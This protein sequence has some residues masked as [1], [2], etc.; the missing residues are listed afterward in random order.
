MTQASQPAYRRFFKIIVKGKATYELDEKCRLKPGAIPKNPPRKLAAE[1]M[2]LHAELNPQPEQ[3]YR[4]T[5]QFLPSSCSSPNSSP[6]LGQDLNS[7]PI[8]NRVEDQNQDQQP[9]S[10]TQIFQ[11]DEPLSWFDEYG[12]DNFLDQQEYYFPNMEENSFYF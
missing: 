6:N 1:L 2:I 10:S 4:L 7:L 9:N 3:S 8:N 12:D 11:E 5:P